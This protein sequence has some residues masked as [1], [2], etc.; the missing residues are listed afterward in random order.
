MVEE[1]ADERGELRD[2][3]RPTSGGG[4]LALVATACL[5]AACGGQVEIKEQLGAYVKML[6]MSGSE[7]VLAEAEIEGADFISF[8]RILRFALG[9]LDELTKGWE[10]P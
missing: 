9:S 2:T 4:R 1:H 5:I 8:Q 3:R 10:G 7:I 6:G